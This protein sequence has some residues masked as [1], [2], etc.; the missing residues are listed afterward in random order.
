MRLYKGDKV[1]DYLYVKFLQPQ[2]QFDLSCFCAVPYTML[3][4]AYAAKWK[5]IKP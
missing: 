4:P 2:W 5:I 1:E 3:S